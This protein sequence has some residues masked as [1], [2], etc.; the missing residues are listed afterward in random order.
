MK[1][2]MFILSPAIFCFEWAF[3]MN[4]IYSKLKKNDNYEEILVTSENSDFFVF[5]KKTPGQFLSSKISK[6][7][8]NLKE[9][10]ENTSDTFPS[11]ILGEFLKSSIINEYQK[12]YIN[13]IDLL[14]KKYFFCENNLDQGLFEIKINSSNYQFFVE[15]KSGVSDRSSWALLDDSI[16]P[17][18]LFNEYLRSIFWV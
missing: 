17:A 15:I 3:T 12:V 6:S 13:K 1:E 16:F 2:V 14:E 9:W 5:T 10:K 18:S 7:G 8:I 11:Q 4:R